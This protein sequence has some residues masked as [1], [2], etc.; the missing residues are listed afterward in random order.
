MYCCPTPVKLE[1][2]L[3]CSCAGAACSSR[4]VKQDVLEESFPLPSQNSQREWLLR[5]EVKAEPSAFS[6]SHLALI[7]VVLKA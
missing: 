5:R 6:S 3:V 1:V 4:S 2:S 7:I